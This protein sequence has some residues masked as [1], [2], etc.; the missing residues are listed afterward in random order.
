MLQTSPLSNFRLSGAVEI[1]SAWRRWIVQ[2]TF[3]PSRTI[4]WISK[5]HT[6]K[7]TMV[8]WWRGSY[9][10]FGVVVCIP[11][12]EISKIVHNRMLTWCARILGA[13]IKSSGHNGARYC[14]CLAWRWGLCW[15]R[16]KVKC[17]MHWHLQ[18]GAIQVINQISFIYFQLDCCIQIRYLSKHGFSWGLKKIKSVC[19]LPVFSQVATWG[20]PPAL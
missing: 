1:L 19:L 14:V 3:S 4:M 16:K 18:R 17:Q 10:Y 12:T 13:F 9:S 6:A 20:H 2:E 15:R 5:C 11:I 7:T 8:P